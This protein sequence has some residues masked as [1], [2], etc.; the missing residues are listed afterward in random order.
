MEFRDL[1][2]TVRAGKQPCSWMPAGVVYYVRKA[3]LEDPTRAGICIF[4]LSTIL[5]AITGAMLGLEPG[6]ER[7]KLMR[8]WQ[9]PDPETG[10]LLDIEALPS[11][12][13]PAC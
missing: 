10:T 7:L 12:S 11:D 5:P 9:C 4:A 8:G 6:D 13:G 1:K 2:I 3:K